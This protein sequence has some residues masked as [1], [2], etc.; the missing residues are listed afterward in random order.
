M[1]IFFYFTS[2]GEDRD[3]DPV[4]SSDTHTIGIGADLTVSKTASPSPAS[5]GEPL[6]YTILVT[7]IGPAAA[8]EVTLTDFAPPELDGA[9]VSLDGQTWRRWA[10]SI[11]LDT[12]PAGESAQVLLRGILN[13]RATGILSNI[14][15][16]GASS[17]D[18]EPANNITSVTTPIR[19]LA[20]L[21]VVKTDTVDPIARGETFTYSIVVENNGPQDASDVEVTETLPAEVNWILFTPSTGSYDEVGGVW[22]I[23]LLAA[24]ESATLTVTVAADPGFTGTLTNRVSV[25]S[26]SDDPN[27][28]N[29]ADVE[30]TTVLE[31]LGGGG[32]LT[33]E[34]LPCSR[35]LAVA[36]PLWFVT[37]EA[38]FASSELLKIQSL[39]ATSDLRKDTL[40]PSGVRSLALKAGAVAFDNL[41]QVEASSGLGID[42]RFGPRILQLADNLGMTPELALEQL[43]DDY[44]RQ[45]GLPSSERPANERWIFLE[46]AAGDPRFTERWEEP[47]SGGEWTAVD[48]RIDPSA[49]G[50]SMLHE[51]LQ[52][53]A[54][55]E[56]E[57]PLD[58]YVALVLTEAIAN[59]L[60]VL[61]ESLTSDV[62]N[63]SEAFASSYT[64]SSGAGTVGLQFTP[65]AEAA[66]LFDYASLL[67]GLA[68]VAEYE[69]GAILSA[70]ERL[71]TRALATVEDLLSG[72][73]ASLAGASTRD[74]GLLLV[75][76]SQVLEATTETQR[77]Q[78][79]GL[80]KRTADAILQV[81][82]GAGTFGATLNP[83]STQVE[84]RQL[85]SQT[86]AL[87]GLL[88]AYSSTM[89]DK[90][91]EG[92]KQAFTALEAVFWEE[93]LQTYAS[94]V[95]G[96][97]RRYCYTP[98]ELGATAGALRGIAKE[99][100]HE[101][102]RATERLAQF[103]HTVV[104][105]AALHLAHAELAGTFGSYFGNG[106]GQVA[107]LQ[108]IDASRGF[109]PVLVARLCINQE[110]GDTACCGV[111]GEPDPWFQTDIA[112]YASYQLQKSL[113]AAEDVAD[114]NLASLVLHSE[115]GEP[116]LRGPY[117]AELASQR[118]MSV[119]R[120]VEAQ[121][122]R[123]AEMAGL[124][125]SDRPSLSPIVLPF[126]SGSPE[127]GIVG[128]LS[129]R[130]ETFF[131]RLEG[132]AVGM[133]LLREA[134]EARQLLSPS[135]DRLRDPSPQEEFYA[136]VLIGNVL[137]K[138][139][140]LDQLSE[141]MERATGSRY[142]PHAAR[143]VEKNGAAG[144]EI[145]DA[146]SLLF[147]QVALMLGLAEARELMGIPTVAE[148]LGT[149][150]LF[151]SS[152]VDLIDSLAT[153]VLSHLQERHFD[154]QLAMYVDQARWQD[155]MWTRSRSVSSEIAGLLV[156][157]LD[158]VSDVFEDLPAVASQGP[159]GTGI[160]LRFL[161]EQPGVTDGLIAAHYGTEEIGAIPQP[162]GPSDLA[163]HLSMVGALM[164]AYNRFGEDQY[165]DAARRVFAQV[166]RELA[167]PSTT[168]T[169]CGQSEAFFA[170]EGELA[171][172]YTP[173][174]IGLAVSAAPQLAAASTP[175]EAA[176]ILGWLEAFYRH[177]AIGTGM[178]LRSY[179]WGSTTRL[180]EGDTERRYAPVFA[181]EACLSVVSVPPLADD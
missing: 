44:A 15:Q 20:D 52:A 48:S 123:Y 133:T 78:I 28:A 24:G 16:V 47:W 161:L 165:L 111:R 62:A 99:G 2:T 21:S 74:A 63:A 151:P 22:S 95:A 134:Q 6:V 88:S 179:V 118:G 107:P 177:A 86:A 8:H 26:L 144:Y 116:L 49:L 67:L 54:L 91:R 29:D 162:A 105:E 138:L 9:E 64:V 71:T 172:C 103:F 13:A 122:T 4:E 53:K 45:A 180:V 69:Q 175:T 19:V 113:T 59:K 157:A 85:I 110:A 51:A 82:D 92:A 120:L 166:R 57:D 163:S 147:D 146:S 30:V 153:T 3:G 148:L 158:R 135:L 132:A 106:S 12:L 58:R 81:Q 90:Y 142:V 79:V 23:G 127:L 94:S 174:E 39:P 160:A 167:V 181:R 124:S 34:D 43:L 77:P 42:L 76:L 121:L 156:Q 84:E 46:Y 70:A 27:A 104:E 11:E 159:I 119:E 149:S 140:F 170:Q 168:T 136:L 33:P 100:G 65:S 32:I 152:P 50:M 83:R 145:L 150:D 115:M 141:E 61:D 169:E 25:Q 93:S 89:D 143:I 5:P 114:S 117:Y 68:A 18:P 178:Q 139:T 164:T 129:W 96:A 72:D 137:N 126:S 155:G 108:V 87:Y 60:T 66:T 109:A 112:M 17:P 56:S 14:A 10:G 75:S 101:A 55:A 36:D 154:A 40:L 97:N 35:A 73:G 31:T 128:S 37:D 7:N 98:L 38:M 176:S 130:P 125:S 131:E 1:C 171:A 80:V 173:W 41:I 102:D